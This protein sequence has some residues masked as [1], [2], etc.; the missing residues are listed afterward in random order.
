MYYTTS[1]LS[2]FTLC[3]FLGLV[4]SSASNAGG[5]GDPNPIPNH[6]VRIMKP[7]TNDFGDVIGYTD[8]FGRVHMGN[9][10]C[11]NV[12]KAAAIVGVDTA[13]AGAAG[14]ANTAAAAA[15]TGWWHACKR[16]LG[17]AGAGVGAVMALDAFAGSANA[18]DGVPPPTNP[19][20]GD[21]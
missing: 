14:A 2:L 13:G 17:I 12:K 16:F 1:R 21:F 9:L 20:G 19:F 7:L 8:Q 5:P 3:L 10:N 15:P 11:A 6:W 4:T 18:A